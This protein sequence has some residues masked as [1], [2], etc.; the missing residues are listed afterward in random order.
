MGHKATAR[1]K[2]GKCFDATEM[3]VR[4]KGIFRSTRLY[5]NVCFR[6]RAG[7]FHQDLTRF[8]ANVRKVAGQ[9]SSRRAASIR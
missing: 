3:S 8:S 6:Q 5:K 4:G 1:V 7:I 2:A 9:Q